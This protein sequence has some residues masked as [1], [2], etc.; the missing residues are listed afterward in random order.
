MPI[1]EKLVSLI[2]EVIQHI[3]RE[4][5]IS[6]SFRECWDAGEGQKERGLRKKRMTPL[7]LSENNKNF[8]GQM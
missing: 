2:G 4:Y 6:G 7:N 1:W 8:R 3:T 5:F